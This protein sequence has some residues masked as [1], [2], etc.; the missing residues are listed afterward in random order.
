VKPVV[1]KIAHPVELSMNTFKRSLLLSLICVS[2]T[3]T[4]TI[5]RSV[6]AFQDSF[7]YHSAD[8][9][10]ALAEQVDGNSAWRFVEK[11]VSEEFT[12]RL[13][14]TEGADKSAEWIANV[15]QMYG[16]KPG[17]SKDEDSYFQPFNVPL[18]EIRVP[19]SLSIISGQHEEPLSYNKD[20][21]VMPFSGSGSIKAPVI[22]AGYG[23]SNPSQDYDEYAR[24]DVK[25]K[26][27]VII[28]KAPAFSAFSETHQ[29]FTN[30]IKLAREKGAK[31]ILFADMP[32]EKNPYPMNMKAVYAH[33][34][35]SMPIFFISSLLVDKLLNSVSTDLR[36]I[37]YQI[38]HEQKPASMP[39][40]IMLDMICTVSKSIEETSN[41]I[42]YLPARTETA[43]SILITAHYDHLGL[44]HIDGSLYAGA[45]DNASGTGTLMEIARAIT[46]Q[47]FT[48][49]VNIVFIAFS[50]EEEGLIGSFHYVRHPLFPI[51]NIRAVFNMDMVG[52]G[53][54]SLLAGTSKSTYP[55][56]YHAIKNSAEALN[57]NLVF[58]EGLIRSGSD[59]YPFHMEKVPNVFFFRSNPE[60]LGGY[61]TPEDTLDTVDPKNLE[62][63]GRLLLLALMELSEPLFMLVDSQD[64][65][66]TEIQKPYLRLYGLGN[67]AFEIEVNDQKIL[68]GNNARFF[69]VVPLQEGVNLIHIVMK[70]EREVVFEKIISIKARIIPELAGDFNDDFKVDMQDLRYLSRHFE[71]QVNATEDWS[72]CDLNRDGIINS[73]DVKAFQAFYGYQGD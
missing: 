1:L 36:S 33:S 41:V 66:K 34:S 7:N 69:H 22:F 63:T 61:H 25:D 4:A 31:G 58:N 43:D 39:L 65:K 53:T 57:I 19:T 23:I 45:N 15:F 71:K 20:F 55:E 68:Q 32:D 49:D 12:G 48:I 8:P 47:C 2:I 26:I 13:S 51:K 6:I 70:L 9:Y 21:T 73:D 72:V 28:R 16:L 46:H 52:T 18:Y 54:G 5:N 11:L 60:G 42:G 64:I 14:G 50:G 29:S 24:I 17:G 38:D 40:N 3:F 44:D 27:V 37:V 35:E 62:E 67:Y 30:K 59:H 56:L 10:I